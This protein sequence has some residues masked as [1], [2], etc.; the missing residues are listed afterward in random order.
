MGSRYPAFGSLASQV[1]TC[2]AIYAIHPLVID[3]PTF[4]SQEGVDPWV[5]IP[6]PYRSNLTYPLM[7][8]PIVLDRLIVVDRPAEPNNLAGAPLANSITELEIINEKAL[9]GWL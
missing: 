5:T 2:K 7:Q 3:V 4:A 8:G 1:Q 9:L 6:H